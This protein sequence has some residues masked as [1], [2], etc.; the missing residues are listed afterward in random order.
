MK[1]FFSDKGSGNG[2][3]TLIENENI[4][5]DDAEIAETFK[6]FFKGAASSLNIGIPEEY[7]MN[8]VHSSD[9]IDVIIS[10]YSNHPSILSINQNVRKGTFSFSP[11]EYDDISKE[12]MALDGNKA[13]MSGTIPPKILKENYHACVNPLIRIINNGILNSEFDESLKCADLVPVHKMDDTTDKTNYR[14]IS[15]L[16][17]VSKIFEKIIQKQIGNYMETFLSPFLCGYRKGYNAQYA[18][19][20]ILEKWRVARDKGGY[21]GAVLMDLSKAFDTLN[22]DLI[23]AKLHAYGFEKSAL[24]LIKSYLS[25][26]WQ[27][28]KINTSLSSWFELI[29]GVPQGSVLGPLL[30]NLFIND[31][32]FIIQETDICNFADDNTL[33]TCDT[34]LDQLMRDLER[35]VEKAIAWF[36]YNGMKLNSSKCHLLI[37]GHKFECMI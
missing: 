26:R 27:R 31:F 34:K 1:P 24:R 35:G 8:V 11:V 6:S 20:S 22:H 28:T 13:F 37:S 19:L 3:I 17:V 18:L 7:T 33:H 15:L 32:F 30:F 10:K 16:P 23:I 2:V 12:L 29:L 5:S 25:N 4:F 9:P 36:E 14:N 21:G